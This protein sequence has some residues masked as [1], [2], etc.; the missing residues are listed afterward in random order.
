MR[1]FTKILETILKA[2]SGYIHLLPTT[3]GVQ[4]ELTNT[5]DT[6]RDDTRFS[7]EHLNVDT[8]GVLQV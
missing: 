7:A 5:E 1:E 6:E 8:Y 2:A 4:E 3:G